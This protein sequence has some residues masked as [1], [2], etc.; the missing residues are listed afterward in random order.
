VPAHVLAIIGGLLATLGAAAGRA[1]P[2]WPFPV[3]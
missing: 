3:A 1:F 2:Q